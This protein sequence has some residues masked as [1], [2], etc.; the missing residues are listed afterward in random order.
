[1]IIKLIDYMGG[2]YLYD[3]NCN[4]VSKISNDLYDVLK[5]CSALESAKDDPTTKAEIEMLLN[6]GFLENRA[7]EIIEHENVP[8]V[9]TFLNHLKRMTLQVTQACNFKCRYCGFAGDNYLNRHHNGLSMSWET[10]KKA[11][12]FFF[13]HSMGSENVNLGFYGGE[14]LLELDLITKCIE[15]TE[16]MFKGRHITYYITSNGSLI[17]EK[18]VS[19]VNEYN[20]KLTISL[21]G[22]EHLHNKNRRYAINGRETYQDVIR[23]INYL[24]ENVPRFKDKI[25][26]NAV[27][28]QQENY[29]PYFHFF[30]ENDAVRGINHSESIIDDSRL[31]RTIFISKDYQTTHDREK[32]NAYINALLGKESYNNVSKEILD[33]IDANK[34]N[35]MQTDG[36]GRR[37]HHNGPCVPG[38]SR[39]FVNVKGELFPCEK[40]SEN[41]KVMCI[42]NIDD[43][44]YYEVIKKLLNIGSMTEKQCKKC[45]AARHCNICAVQIDDID[46]LSLK[47]KQIRCQIQERNLE[48]TIKRYIFFCKVGL[49]KEEL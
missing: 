11:I 9:K 21:D 17:N 4:R 3:A 6:E 8:F 24:R 15:Y 34:E 40:C 36:F 16:E 31:S 13:I 5:K 43:G 32:I 20:V 23:G 33:D 47:Q 14:T 37:F 41:S 26:I 1:M 49:L 48:E 28:D 12:D 22:P 38:Y 42:G 30:E 27:I 44:Y 29:L 2:K 45:V 39:L 35:F 25:M 46:D 10:A 18:V 7:P 19:L